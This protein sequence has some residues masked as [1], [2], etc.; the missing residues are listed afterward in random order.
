MHLLTFGI[1]DVRCDR[2]DDAA[3]QFLLHLEDV[4]QHPV[5]LLGPQV[6]AGERVDQLAADADALGRLADAAFQHVAHA[7]F[8]AHAANVGRLPLYEND[9]LRAMTNSE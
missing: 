6:V 7:E 2:R 5:V 8:L 9:E 4:L 3:R 1:V